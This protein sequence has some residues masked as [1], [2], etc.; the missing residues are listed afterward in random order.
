LGSGAD[1]IS[2]QQTELEALKNQLLASP[3]KGAD[4]PKSQDNAV[5][6]KVL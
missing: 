4:R 6:N 2:V 3:V 1:V 5:K